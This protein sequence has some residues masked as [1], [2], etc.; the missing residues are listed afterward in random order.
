MRTLDLAVKQES[1]ILPRTRRPVGR[2]TNAKVTEPGLARSK[3]APILWEDVADPQLTYSDAPFRI[4][5]TR[6]LPA[7]KASGAPT[8]DSNSERKLWLFLR[9]KVGESEDWIAKRV[10]LTVAFL[11][12]MGI[13]SALLERPLAGTLFLSTALAALGGLTFLDYAVRGHTFMN[14]QIALGLLVIGAGNILIVVI[15]TFI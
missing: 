4:V 14:I 8:S 6:P 9:T 11:L 12:G 7:G 15:G 13:L 1:Q 10:H 5:R 2:R 3:K